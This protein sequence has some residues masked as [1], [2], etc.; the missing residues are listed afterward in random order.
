MT[1]LG[2]AGCAAE[3]AAITSSTVR[4]RRSFPHRRQLRFGER[5]R[6]GSHVTKLGPSAGSWTPRIRRPSHGSPTDRDVRHSG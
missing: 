2:A 3:Y 1:T 5:F 6:I 4:T